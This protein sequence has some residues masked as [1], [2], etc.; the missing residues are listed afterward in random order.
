MVVGKVVEDAANNLAELIKLEIAAKMGLSPSDIELRSGTFEWDGGAIGF[1]EAAKEIAARKGPLRARAEFLDRDHLAWDD[2]TY[3]GDAYPCFSWAAVATEVEV[4]MDTY[5]PRVTRFITAQ[6]IG[7]AIHPILAAGQI[8]GGSLQGLGWAS[9][10]EVK[11]ENG[12]YLNHHLTD[13]IIPTALDAPEM[14][15]TIVEYP[16]KSGPHGAKGVGEMPMDLPAP[17]MAAAMEQA[18]GVTID[19][20]PFTPEMICAALEEVDL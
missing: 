9:M 2:E 10:E 18:T 19:R 5:I 17:A 8:E 16:Y 13:C 14:D 15:V 3:T 4:D 6:D 12:R 20:T 7:K 11:M 1:R